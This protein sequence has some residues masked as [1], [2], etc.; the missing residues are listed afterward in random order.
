MGV[1]MQFEL[2]LLDKHHKTK[3]FD[4]G[5]KALNDYLHHY[6]LKNEG[7]P[8]GQTYLAIDNEGKIAGYFTIWVAQ[9]ERHELPDT[10]ATKKLPGY[11]V[12][13]LRIGRLAV[14][15]DMQ[16]KGVGSFLMFKIY[17]KALSIAETAGLALLLVDAKNEKAAAFYHRFGFLSY[18]DNPLILF[19]PLSWAR[20]WGKAGK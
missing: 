18:Q 6:A 12:P 19:L 17:E 3:E 8:I 13:A 9:A 10:D 7:L 5:V 1:K 2:E 11:P 20:E 14:R 4:C 15:S 16:G